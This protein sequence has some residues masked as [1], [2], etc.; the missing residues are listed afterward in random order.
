MCGIIAF[1]HSLVTRESLDRY[2]YEILLNGLYQL[3]NR[4]Y[5]SVGLSV[6]LNDN[7]HFMWKKSSIKN[8]LA[9][10]IF[11]KSLPDTFLY[12]NKCRMG[13]AHTRW[14]TH[15]SKT[16]EN[17]H[18]HS[19]CDRRLFLIH[20]GIIENYKDLKLPEHV[21]LSQTDTEVV[22][23][24]L[25]QDL[26]DTDDVIVIMRHFVEQ[27]RNICGT[28]AFILQFAKFPGK[29]WVMKHGSPLCVGR[30]E[31]DGDWYLAS[32]PSALPVR[33][34]YSIPDSSMFM[35][36]DTSSN[37]LVVN[38]CEIEWVSWEEYSR[39]LDMK[40]KPDYDEM[41]KPDTH[42]MLKEILEQPE[43]IRRAINYGGRLPTNVNQWVHLGGLMNIDL[44]EAFDSLCLV[45][46]GTSLYASQWGGYWI[47]KMLSIRVNIVDASE[48]DNDLWA[49]KNTVYVYLSQ[50]GETKDVHRALC[51]LK[52][53]S[54]P[55][56]FIQLGIINAV[57]SL[58]ARDLGQG[59]Y[60]NAGIERAV[61]STKSFT[62]QCITLGLLLMWLYER[63]Y[64][65]SYERTN[66]REILLW[67]ENLLGLSDT[68]ENWLVKSSLREQVRRI[69]GKIYQQQ[70]CFCL[71]RKSMV[72]IAYEAALKLKEVSYIHAEGFVGGALKHGPFSLLRE[73]TPVILFSS[74]GADGEESVKK[75]LIVAEEVKARGAFVIWVSDTVVHKMDEEI[76]VPGVNGAWSSLISI[77]PI[78]LLAYEMALLSGINPDYPRNLAKV[79]TVD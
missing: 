53:V 5:D 32:E 74:Q 18:P 39:G 54:R 71:G 29:I 14:A 51:E 58:I 43:V 45:G 49:R 56:E 6:F 63:I 17:A 23:H 20:N 8:R 46:C 28:W 47:R 10:N 27:M 57:E 64:R 78:Q 41:V 37:L 36:E 40:T 25:E 67:K 75:Q 7:R 50:S 33:D 1:L 62:A 2:G 61:A 42:W 13:M 70:H 68:V 52:R 30:G 76:I 65:D 31:R 55:G 19:C 15:G 60:C 3:Q 77:I 73:G 66:N 34:Y 11:E 35:I 9:L 72:S 44:G 16:D 69:A 59:I 79:V 24:Y 26:P 22:V 4:G 38:D 12:K 21:Y 48:W